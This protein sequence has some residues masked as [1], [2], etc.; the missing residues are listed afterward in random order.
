MSR[1]PL[2]VGVHSQVAK[3]LLDSG[4]S[5]HSGVPCCA[6]TSTKLIVPTAMK[7]P[8]LP[9]LGRNAARNVIGWFTSPTGGTA[10]TPRIPVSR[11]TWPATAQG[12]P[13]IGGAP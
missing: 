4:T 11:Q 1:P 10:E 7:A 9:H 2:E 5:V 8:Q 12:L 13:G 6:L 3:P